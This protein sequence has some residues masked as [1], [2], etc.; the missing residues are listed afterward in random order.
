MLGYG[1]NGNRL[2]SYERNE[3]MYS[4]DVIFNENKYYKDECKVNKT[5][6]NESSFEDYDTE[7]TDSLTDDKLD[8][9]DTEASEDFKIDE[10]TCDVIDVDENEPGTLPQRTKKI[11]SKLADY[12]LNFMAMFAINFVN[13]V[14]EDIDDITR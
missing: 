12:D 7:N 2:W 1:D 6:M 11:P 14:P 5:A 4:T 13:N 8:M 3:M 10:I 9:N